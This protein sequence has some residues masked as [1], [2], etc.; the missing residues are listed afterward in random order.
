MQ[1][2]PKDLEDPPA[3]DDYT[4]QLLWFSKSDRESVEEAIRRKDFDGLDGCAYSKISFINDGYCRSE[5]P[6]QTFKPILQDLWHLYYEVG[7]NVPYSSPE[8]DKWVLHILKAR[9]LGNLTR[10]APSSHNG[11]DGDDNNNKFEIA[12]T[13]AGFL[14]EDLPFFTADMTDF[15]VKDCATMS[16]AQRVNLSHFLAKLVSTGVDDNLCGIALLVFQDTF[17]TVRS[18]GSLADQNNKDPHRTLHDLTITDLLPAAQAWL[19]SAS[20]KIIQLSDKLWNGLATVK[21]DETTFTKSELGRRSSAAFSPWRW[22]YWLKRLEEIKEEAKQA[23]EDALAKSVLDTMEGMLS[24]VEHTD[25]RV[26]RELEAVGNLVKNQHRF[27]R[28]AQMNG[29]VDGIQW[30]GDVGTITLE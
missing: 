25:T 29:E 4:A 13:S 6:A 30:D 20:Y 26:Q 16:A 17:E 2:T 28:K 10:Q 7:K 9:G 8:Q 18:M 15:W 14:W 5:R 3:L 11:S 21:Q 27:S 22:M 24:V 23:G 12:T 19:E 1:D